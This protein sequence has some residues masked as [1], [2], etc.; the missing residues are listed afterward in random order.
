MMEFVKFI[1]EIAIASGVTIATSLAGVLWFSKAMI[2][3]KITQGIEA[4]KVQ[5]NSRLE[6]YKTDLNANLEKIKAD[7][8]NHVNQKKAEFEGIVKKE[9]DTHLGQLAAQR[10]YEYD[11]RKRL[12]S[13]IGP[14]RF[15]LLLA[16][17]DLT[18][19]VEGYA[20]HNYSTS[21]NT[22]YGKSTLYRLLRPIAI[23]ELIEQQI[24]LA[25]F[26]VDEDAIACLLFKKSATRIWS[27]EEV[28]CG[29]EDID[30]E[31]EHQHVFSDSI[32]I[33]ANSMIKREPGVPDRILRYDEYVELL[34]MHKLEG[35]SPFRDLLKDFEINTKP[36]VWIRL[37]AY[38]NSCN[39][40]VTKI[41]AKFGFT[42]E[43]FS[44]TPLLEK[45]A[46]PRI[47]EKIAEFEDKFGELKLIPL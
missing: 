39:Y 47:K 30:W 13:A 43:V 5:L 9:V 1:G 31:N 26:S 17:R 37:V 6:K 32:S 19:R 25:D 10:Q 3:K 41:G 24:A 38:A 8:L 21:I 2:Q 23:A 33:S 11:A 14:L 34:N 20:I 46:A 16:C 15:Q 22:Y 27:G 29:Y 35:I 42:R 12:Y 7:L 18:R 36:I 40:F 45:I 44:I 4:Y 28:T